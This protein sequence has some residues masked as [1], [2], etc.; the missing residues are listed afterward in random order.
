MNPDPESRI[1]PAITLRSPKH[2]LDP[3]TATEIVQV[4]ALLK[5]YGPGSGLH[6]K[7]IGIIEPPK[8]TLRSFLSSERDGLKP[9]L[10]PRRASA[11]FYHRGTSDLFLAEVDL[12]ANRVDKIE[13]LKSRIHAQADIDEAV[14]MRD[15]CLQHPKVLEAVKKFK[16]PEDLT[17]VCDTWPYGRDHG[18]EFP[19]SVQVRTCLPI[20]LLPRFLTMTSATSSHG[21]TIQDPTTM[22]FH[23]PSLLS[24][25]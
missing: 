17:V 20:V 16:I 15:L 23:F 13:Q 3:L 10:P 21:E 4:S 9:A 5:P 8:S 7:A 11:L 18:E 19:R 2:P 12:N 6:F 1:V 14:A 25:T 24:L 22:T